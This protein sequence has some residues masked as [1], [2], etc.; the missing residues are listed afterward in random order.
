MSGSSSAGRYG[1]ASV[2]S[3]MSVAKCELWSSQKQ[4]PHRQHC[5]FRMVLTLPQREL[6]DD[7]APSL[8]ADIDPE[9]SDVREGDQEGSL[10]LP[11]KRPN[12][13]S[14]APPIVER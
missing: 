14:H 8:V 2:W 10:Y 6:V 11:R 13:F 7:L 9:V 4:L 5:V 12:G 3:R 1:I